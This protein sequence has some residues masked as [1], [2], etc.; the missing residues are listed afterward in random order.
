MLFSLL[1]RLL[2]LLFFCFISA[3]WDVIEAFDTLVP[4]LFLDF[5]LRKRSRASRK[6]AT[7]SLSQ[8]V[9]AASQ[10][11]LDL[12]RKEKSRKTSGTRVGL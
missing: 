5:S 2:F 8:L 4:E 6:A 10:L 12:F 11:A 1:L 3:I 9:V 7:T